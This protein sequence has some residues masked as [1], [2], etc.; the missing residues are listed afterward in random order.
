MIINDIMVIRCTVVSLLF[1]VPGLGHCQHIN[2]SL[3]FED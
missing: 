3:R 1:N 2:I